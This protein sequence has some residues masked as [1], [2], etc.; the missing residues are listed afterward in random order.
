M[1]QDL[2][3]QKVAMLGQSIGS[4]FN[5][6]YPKKDPYKEKVQENNLQRIDMEQRDREYD[7]TW[8]SIYDETDEATPK[9]NEQLFREQA[10]A[11]KEQA[12]EHYGDMFNE[13]SWRKAEQKGMINSRALQNYDAKRGEIVVRT[14]MKDSAGHLLNGRTLATS[15]DAAGAAVEL[16]KAYETGQRIDPDWQGSVTPTGKTNKY[17]EPLF[18]VVTTNLADAIKYDGSTE[19]GAKKIGRVTVDNLTAEEVKQHMGETLSGNAGQLVPA[20]IT[21]QRERRIANDNALNNSESF[22]SSTPEDTG[23]AYPDGQPVD[24][25]GLDW[26]GSE[27]ISEDGKKSYIIHGNGADEQ[28]MV[29]ASKAE[30]ME[31]MQLVKLSPAESR[32]LNQKYTD[33][34]GAPHNGPPSKAQRSQWYREIV[35]NSNLGKVKGA[36]S[37]K[38]RD[39]VSKVQSAVNNLLDKGD[40]RHSTLQSLATQY[41]GGASGTTTS[42]DK[43]Q[44]Q[45]AAADAA[46]NA[47]VADLNESDSKK[48]DK[49]QATYR[50]GVAAYFKAL[51]AGHRPAVTLPGNNE[52]SG[53]GSKTDEE[54]AKAFKKKQQKY[55]TFGRI[56]DSPDATV[57]ERRR[58]RRNET[59][60]QQRKSD[61]NSLEKQIILAKKAVKDKKLGS[62]DR[63]AKLQKKLKDLKDLQGAE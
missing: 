56:A 34:Y 53:K 55:R 19:D 51:K 38:E 5:T 10:L 4:T 49:V 36:G 11:R 60:T 32:Q 57:K 40:P 25:G 18:S 54:K 22:V 20:Y 41:A 3:A 9:G 16:T 12:R 23:V 44:G 26:Q 37:G 46:G 13:L 2:A 33:Y 27:H 63:L 30:A 29:F 24:T 17:G 15:G 6:L 1:P 61:V 28:G 45:V 21:S 39:V 35:A 43:I 31:K 42:Q 48:G 14:A 47:R 58:N 8:A 50:A 52:D 59:L 62:A 7:E